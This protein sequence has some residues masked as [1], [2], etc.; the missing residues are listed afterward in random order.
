[1]KKQVLSLLTAAL[2][3]VGLNKSIAQVIFFVE[4]PANLVGNYSFTYA[5]NWGGDLLNNSVSGELAF[6]LDGT[7]ADSLACETVV[8][9]ANVNGKIAVV[10]RGSC[11]FSTK[12]LNAQ[13]AGAIAVVIIN[14]VPGAPVGMAAGDVA[15]LV[16]I[17]VVMISQADGELLRPAI[18]AGEVVVFIGNKQGRFPND[19]ATSIK[20][21]VFAKNFSTPALIA[22]NGTDLSIPF[23][24]WVFNTGQNNQSNVSITTT[25][26]LNGNNVYNQTSNPV[27]INSGD[28]AYF[29]MPVFAPSSFAPGFYEGKYEINSATVDDFPFDNVVNFNFWIGDTVF[30]KSSVTLNPFTPA[31]TNGLRPGDGGEV[32]WCVVIDAPNASR[33][34]GNAITFSASTL[35][36]TNLIDEVIQARILKWNDANGNGIITDDELTT[37]GEG[38]YV[39]E[40]DLQ[41]QFITIPLSNLVSTDPGVPLTDNSIHL[42]CITYNGSKVFLGVDETYN[43]RTTIDAY[44]QIQF[45]LKSSQWFGGGFGSGFVPAIFVH[46][47]DAATFSVEDLTIENIQTSVYPNP[48][49]DF[50]N[51]AM[52]VDYQGMLDI[53]LVDMSGRMVLSQR[54]AMENNGIVT[55]NT[56]NIKS[57]SYIFT[58]TFENGKQMSIP[59]IINKF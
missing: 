29:T 21:V 36:E 59:I 8:N 13:E 37:L 31:R 34:V 44:E 20:D 5:T 51:I 32:Q 10:Y 45:P 35:P 43:Y 56:H 2:L 15:G 14:N 12:A 1:M 49:S 19:L 39:Y 17:P 28:S 57:G 54:V 24:A 26:T 3:I 9:T 40:A 46:L 48:A 27:N 50:V 25:V 55:L 42:G 58:F 38:F 52:N 11:Q 33:M 7:S 23:G 4:E 47:Q 30:S 18:N 16:N 22:Q 53:R 41:N 6:A